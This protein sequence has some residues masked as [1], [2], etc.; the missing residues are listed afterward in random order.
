MHPELKFFLTLGFL[1][2]YAVG[3]FCYELWLFNLVTWWWVELMRYREIFTMFQA[4]V[5]FGWVAG[6]TIMMVPL[7]AWAP[8]WL[9]KELMEIYRQYHFDKPYEAKPYVSYR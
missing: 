2:A 7:F 8:V 5:N 1:I 4:L 9:F 6:T 3:F